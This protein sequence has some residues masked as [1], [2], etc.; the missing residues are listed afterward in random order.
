[1]NRRSHWSI[2]LALAL[3]SSGC[4]A[5]AAPPVGRATSTGF[6]GAAHNDTSTPFNLVHLPRLIRVRYDGRALR[7]RHVVSERLVV[8]HHHVTYR[9]G[10]LRVSGQL[11]VPRRPGRFPLVVLTHG[12]E[13]PATYRSG[14]ALTREVAH[15]TSHGYVVMQP[16]YR[17]HGESDREAAR[18]VARPLGYPEDVLNAIRAVRRATRPCRRGPGTTTAD[19]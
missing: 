13:N 6:V 11:N 4:A 8:T 18:Y 14:A 9:S 2:L 15:L 7:F 3:I 10:R 1:V 12:Y 16:D 17:N 5:A 19:G